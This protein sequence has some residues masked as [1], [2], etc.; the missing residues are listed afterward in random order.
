MIKRATPSYNW[1]CVTGSVGQSLGALDHPKDKSPLECAKREL[2]EETGF[3]ILYSV[4]STHIG[5]A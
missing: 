5:P 2:L 4:D 1:Q 3:L